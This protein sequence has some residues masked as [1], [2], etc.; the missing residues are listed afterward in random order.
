MF[1]AGLGPDLKRSPYQR[2]GGAERL[3]F[4]L[5]NSGISLVTGYQA[6][7]HHVFGFS[8]NLGYQELSVNGLEF[9]DNAGF[10][11]TPGK[12]TN[13]GKD[14]AFNV[15]FTVGWTGE[16]IEGLKLSLS[17]RSKQWTEKH[18]EYRGL[19]PDQG[20]L[21]LPQIY[22][23]GLAYQML[24]TL[25]VAIDYQHYQYTDEP[26]FGNR[27]SDATGLLGSDDGASFGFAN[28]DAYKLGL[29][30][31][32]SSSWTLR[33]GGITAS[34]LS[35][36]S[37]QFF[38]M[39]GSSPST[40]HYTLGTTYRWQGWEVSAN[41]AH[42][43]RQRVQGRNSVPPALGGGE[44]RGSFKTNSFG[45]SLGKTFGGAGR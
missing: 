36:P 12:V 23:G 16:V 25:V 27:F 20:S 13:Q 31:H 45:L 21:E 9:A 35:Q 6:S 42:A 29:F 30:W 4:F 39:I 15:G 8:L 44:A 41:F 11:E 5:V 28:Q 1:S 24:P 26:G 40:T 7:E 3:S 37:E 22:G 34:R 33:A 10:S 38:G 43:P 18:E 19:L 32:A 17:Y 14:G 2:F